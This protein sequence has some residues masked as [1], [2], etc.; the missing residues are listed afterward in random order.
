MKGARL[1]FDYTILN[2]DGKIVSTAQTTLVFVAKGT[3]RPIPPPN[4]FVKLV[5]PHEQK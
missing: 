1:E 5:Q 2:E 3:M 4:S